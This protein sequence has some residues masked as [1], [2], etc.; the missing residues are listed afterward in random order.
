MRTLLSAIEKMLMG[1]TPR[2]TNHFFE[3]GLQ[4]LKKSIAVLSA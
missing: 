2:S 1:I 4:N 3:I